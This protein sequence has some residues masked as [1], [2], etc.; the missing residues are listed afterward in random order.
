MNLLKTKAILILGIVSML[1]MLT[2]ISSAKELN[3]PGFSGTINT[4]VTSGFTA[5]VSDQNCELH[6][7]YNK[8]YTASDIT[9]TAQAA[10]GGAGAAAAFSAKSDAFKAVI[11]N[12]TSKNKAGCAPKAKTDAYGNVAESHVNIGNVN[13][14][15]GKL[16]FE[17]GDIVDATQR[18]F[19]SVSGKTDSGLGVN[20]SIA[21]AVNP[22]LDISDP[23]FK[24]LSSKAENTLDHDFSILDAYITSSVDTADGGYVDITLGRHVTSWGEAT[25]IPVGLNGLVTNAVDLTKLRAPGSAIREALTPT[26]QITLSSQLGDWGVEGYLQFSAE[27]VQIDPAGSYYGNEVVGAGGYQILASGA[28]GMES[29]IGRDDGCTWVGVMVE[30]LGCDAAGV[31]KHLAV[32]TR[33]YYNTKTLAYNAAVNTSA[34]LWET[35]SGVARGLDFGSGTLYTALG[36]ANIVDNGML[37]YTSA[38]GGGTALGGSIYT[39]SNFVANDYTSKAT[40]ELRSHDNKHVY[41]KDGGQWGIKASRFFD[42]IGE[43]LDLGF[44]YA[45]YHS[46]VPYLRVVGKGGVLAGDHI[47]MFKTQLADYGS[48]GHSILNSLTLEGYDVATQTTNNINGIHSRAV[49]DGLAGL[50]TALPLNVIAATDSLSGDSLASLQA[51]FAF[52]NGS[53]SSGV[54]GGFTVKATGKTA[55]DGATGNDISEEAAKGLLQDLV[56]GNLV[57]GR[58]Y[59]KP[60][61]CQGGGARDAASS[62]AYLTYGATLLAAITPLNHA[63]YQLIYPEDNQILGMSFSTNIDGMTVQGEVSYRPD[64]PLSTSLGDQINQI[65]DASG[66][67]AGLSMFAVESYGTSAASAHALNTYKGIVD[68]VLGTDGFANLVINNR[69]SSLPFLGVPGLTDYNSTAFIEHDVWSFDVGTTSTFSASHPITVGLGADSAVFL[70]ELAAVNIQGM[71]NKKN[72]FVARNGFNEGNG[73]H[74]C[75]GIFAFTTQ[76]NIDAINTAA[77][78]STALAGYLTGEAEVAIDYVLDDKSRGLTNMGASIIDPLFGNGSYCENQMGADPFSATY[79][80]VGSAT[81]NNVNNSPWTLKPSVAFAHD[82]MGYGPS[83]LGGF[84][85]DKASINLGLT[86]SKGESINISLNYTNQMGPDEAN[87]INDRDTVSASVS[88][89]F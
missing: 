25:F 57:D 21:G 62:G 38:S 34:T 36:I 63:R 43:G 64:F 20:F 65:G 6:D 49:N 53:F 23:A 26:E 8:Q 77:A 40:V 22:V 72:G 18:F 12:Q 61:V 11:L 60:T 87:T 27:Q 32:A 70:T 19:T 74:L 3:I 83:S 54:C 68:G 76:A 4:T 42:D 28:S 75:L 41:A 78:N 55:I 15:D 46:K 81:Y 31:A 48:D 69:R 33:D 59:H 58:V 37:T 80:L 24:K 5:R 47:G 84:V 39:A 17:Q 73:E 79:R 2:N 7:G 30:G 88:Y 10:L 45:N 67:T 14:D 1:S 85:E 56:F 52:A 35:Y 66:A 50:G 29:M 9:S 89:A 51:F 71:D 82:F 16:N 13:S 86:A 44:Y